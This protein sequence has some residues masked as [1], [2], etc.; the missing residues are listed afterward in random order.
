M[1]KLKGLLYSVCMV[2]YIFCIMPS[3]GLNEVSIAQAAEKKPALEKNRV[4]LIMG[5]NGYE[6]K[7]LNTNKNATITYTSKNKKIATVSKDGMVTPVKEGSTTITVAIKQNSKSYTLSLEVTVKYPEKLSAVEIYENCDPSV[8]ELSC[9]SEF[10]SSLGSGFFIDS[11]TVV[12]NYHVIKGAKEIVVTTKDKVNHKVDTILGYNE[13][14]D[15]AILKVESKTTPLK[16]WSSSSK[17]GEDV[18]ALGSPLG[19]TGTISKGMITMASREFD[20]VN[21]IQMDAAISP[22]NSGGPLINAYGQVIGINTMYLRSGQN[23]NFAVNISELKK[24]DVSKPISLKDYYN[25][26]QKELYSKAI[27]ENTTLTMPLGGGQ[28][29]DSSTLVAGSFTIGS[30]PDR[31]II[32]VSDTGW[33]DGVIKFDSEDEVDKVSIKVL[34]SSLYPVGECYVNKRGNLLEYSIYLTPGTYYFDFSISSRKSTP[35]P[36][37]IY[38][39]YY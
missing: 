27:K 21:Y 17:A 5:D 26:Y 1:R 28:L 19:L 9:Q 12:T 16:I 33:V 8:V 11:K 39:S 13:K 37:Y 22:G 20:G 38:L 23:V 4:T 25:K 29:V 36:Y 30:I 2:V 10:F 7:L 15:I 31:Y 24:V 14:L 35:I 32:N 6:I 18:Y 34:N 3:L